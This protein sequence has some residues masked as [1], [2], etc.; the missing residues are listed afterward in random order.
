[1]AKHRLGR[2]YCDREK[3]KREF[4]F[5]WKNQKFIE[6]E[7]TDNIEFWE[8]QKEEYLDIKEASVTSSSIFIIDDNAN[9]QKY[10]GVSLWQNFFLKYVAVRLI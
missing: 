6:K 10:R 3:V 4:I 1:M 5:R 8:Q 2:I 7:D 9:R